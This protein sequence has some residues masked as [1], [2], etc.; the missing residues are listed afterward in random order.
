MSHR[1]ITA[2]RLRR[3]ATV[4][5]AT[6]LAAAALTPSAGADVASDITQELQAAGLPNP[7]VTVS[8]PAPAT[9]TDLAAFDADPT[10]GYA[11]ITPYN[12]ISP[13]PSA[14]LPVATVRFGK[15]SVTRLPGFLQ[16]PGIGSYLAAE[17]AE[18]P[19][20]RLQIMLAIKHRIAAGASLAGVAMQPQFPN[21]TQSSRPDSYVAAQSTSNFSPGPY[22]QT[23]PITDVEARLKAELPAWARSATVSVAQW[24]GS[25]RRA[26]ITHSLPAPILAATDVHGLAMYALEKQMELNASGGNVGSVVIKIHDPALNQ[27][28]LTFAG[29]ATW[30]QQFSWI[31]PLIKAATTPGSIGAALDPGGDILDQVDHAAQDADALVP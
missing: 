7:Q 14:P 23:M 25:E 31:S 4:L 10:P 29:D 11:S 30:G 17:D 12:L 26:V 1:T 19:V 16:A 15:S 22:P 13:N 3:A 18:F 8:T 21:R 24:A 28:L 5:A 6:V 9:A 20:W 2:A 27:P